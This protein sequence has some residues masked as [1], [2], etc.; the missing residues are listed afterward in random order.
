MNDQKIPVTELIFTVIGE[1]AVSMLTVAVYLI[2]EKYNYTV[3]C[4]VLLGGA[5][6]LLNFIF[7][8]IAIN[9]ALDDV[10]TLRGS[11]AMDD[12]EATKFA[13]EH[14][15]RLKN[16]VLL[17]NTVRTFSIVAVLVAAFLIGHFDVIAT[18]IPIAAFRPILM[19]AG[20]VA[21]KGK[22]LWT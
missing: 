17:S 20:L 11:A 21:G 14:N 18:V 5:V 16:A 13:A 2:L 22:A 8:C 4:G 1:A 3:L 15:G 7:L 9:R 19:L 10:V 12:E 6:I